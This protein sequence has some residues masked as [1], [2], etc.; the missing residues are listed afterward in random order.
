MQTTDKLKAR[1]ML[2]WNKASWAM[3]GAG[4]DA[5]FCVFVEGLCS[6]CLH[7]LNDLK[8]PERTGH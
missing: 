7:Y 2:A 3:D 8:I 5:A 4:R 6:S 1:G